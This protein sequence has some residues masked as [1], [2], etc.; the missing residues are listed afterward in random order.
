M[1]FKFQINHLVLKILNSLSLKGKPLLRMYTDE[2]VY[3]SHPSLG[4]SFDVE[5]QPLP[6]V[7]Y[8]YF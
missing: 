5:E 6:A 7:G 4:G 1:P 8:C 3:E 2:G